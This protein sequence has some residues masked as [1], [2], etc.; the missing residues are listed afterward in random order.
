MPITDDD[1][2]DM[3]SGKT[4]SPNNCALADG[5][6]GSGI[7]P[8]LSGGDLTASKEPDKVESLLAWC[9]CFRLHNYMWK[10]AYLP[11][12]EQVSDQRVLL[13]LF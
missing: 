3:W 8:V 2:A 12:E 6:T 1:L 13:V 9:G 5:S 10:R 4:C 11:G 7:P